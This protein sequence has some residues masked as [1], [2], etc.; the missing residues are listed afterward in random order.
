MDCNST[1]HFQKRN[2]FYST[3]IKI[4]ERSTSDLSRIALDTI[5]MY[6]PT[7][8]YSILISVGERTDKTLINGTR[9]KKLESA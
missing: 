5:A 7:V 2:N 3:S 9:I 6:R 4:F 8:I 1:Q